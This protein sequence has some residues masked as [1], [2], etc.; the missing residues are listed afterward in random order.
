VTQKVGR[1]A[2]AAVCAVVL[3]GSG[4]NVASQA[5]AAAATPVEVAV[6]AADTATSFQNDQVWPV[7]A[8][9]ST[10]AQPG[11]MLIWAE[12]VSGQLERSTRASHSARRARR[13]SGCS[14]GRACP[15]SSTTASE[16]CG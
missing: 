15:A 11:T 6:V 2:S 3:V 16:V 14:W 8:L 12:H 4:V 9:H 5:D 1:R 13:S 7:L 10:R